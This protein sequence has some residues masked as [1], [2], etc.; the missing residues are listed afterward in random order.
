MRPSGPTPARQTQALA[1]MV[2]RRSPSGPARTPGRAGRNGPRSRAGW[3]DRGATELREGTSRKTAGRSHPRWGAST[4]AGYRHAPGPS[5]SAEGRPHQQG[6]PWPAP[7]PPLWADRIQCPP[8]TRPRTRT[9]DPPGPGGP[10]PRPAASRAELKY[11]KAERCGETHLWPA[12]GGGGAGTHIRESARAPQ[13]PDVRVPGGAAAS[14]PPRPARCKGGV[15][16][17]SPQ[18]RAAGVQDSSL[19][20]WTHFPVPRSQSSPAPWALTPVP[21]PLAARFAKSRLSGRLSLIHLFISSF[22]YLLIS[23]WTQIYLFFPVVLIRCHFYC[24]AL[25]YLLVCQSIRIPYH[26]FFFI[27]RKIC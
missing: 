11:R 5:S 2:G 13:D 6:Q 15:P 21:P 20:D 1:G 18:P 24:R 23:I 7:M 22:N 27:L 9:H 12:S 8:E 3:Y 10:S 26:N 16:D 4:T 25:F 14:A 17:L 19:G